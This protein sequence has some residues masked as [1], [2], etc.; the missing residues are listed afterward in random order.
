VLIVEVS[1]IRNQPLFIYICYLDK[2][3]IN[4]LHGTYC[5]SCH[6]KRYLVEH[7]DVEKLRECKRSAENRKIPFNDDDAEIIKEKFKLPC[8]YCKYLPC[9]KLNGVD[10]VNSSGT[11]SDN[12]TTSCCLVCNLMKST[13]N[14][15]EFVERVLKIYEYRNLE[16]CDEK[17]EDAFYSR[18]M[19]YINGTNDTAH[20]GNMLLIF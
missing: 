13:S 5:E 16:T 4:Q 15:R 10:R 3:L 19:I 11:Y 2:F 18:K 8:S 12:N 20:K 9:D 6:R 7:A 17:F 14:L 1:R